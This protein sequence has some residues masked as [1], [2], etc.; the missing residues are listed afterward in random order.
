MHSHAPV[1]VS[2]TETLTWP[3]GPMLGLMPPTRFARLPR[4]GSLQGQRYYSRRDLSVEQPWGQRGDW[5]LRFHF[6]CCC[7][8]CNPSSGAQE[9]GRVPWVY[10]DRWLLLMTSKLPVASKCLTRVTVGV[11]SHPDSPK[12]LIRQLLTIRQLTER[13]PCC[14]RAKGWNPRV[15]LC[16]V[17]RNINSSSRT[18][19]PVTRSSC[20]NT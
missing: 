13:I 4:Q 19:Q 20:A 16:G 12:S 14:A 1:I 9:L 3:L 10:F 17:V 8:P 18:P 2:V 6:H 15:N 11:I 5:A 7:N